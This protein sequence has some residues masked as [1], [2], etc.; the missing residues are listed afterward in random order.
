V[1]DNKDYRPYQDVLQS[2][3]GV[4]FFGVPNQGIRYE[5]LMRM[6]EGKRTEEFVRGLLTNKD[7]EISG[8]LS[9]LNRDF[10]RAQNHFRHG[11]KAGLNML[12]Y[13]EKL[14]TLTSQ[15]SPGHCTNFYKLIYSWKVES[16]QPVER[17]LVTESS[18]TYTGAPSKSYHLL[19]ME[20]DHRSMIKFRTVV[21]PGYMSV[22]GMI[23]EF[24]EE[25]IGMLWAQTLSQFVNSVK[26]VPYIP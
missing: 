1:A 5:E 15:V 22:K 16:G 14:K 4:V 10:G 6:V 7:T 9:A 11:E 24:V 23:Q 17:L 18:A 12:C 20:G 19:P 26:L 8:V 13:Y 21:D 25:A 2:C 3:Y